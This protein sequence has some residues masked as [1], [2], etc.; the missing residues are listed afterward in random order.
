V[1]TKLTYT[2]I[3]NFIIISFW[4]NQSPIL[5]SAQTYN[6]KMPGAKRISLFL[7]SAVEIRN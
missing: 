7:S 6:A 1:V 4:V 5:V 3:Y 2:V